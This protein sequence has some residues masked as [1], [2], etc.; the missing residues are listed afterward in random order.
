MV[1]EEDVEVFAASVLVSLLRPLTRQRDAWDKQLRRGE[2]KFVV[3]Q[4]DQ[5]QRKEKL[6]YLGM[7][8]GRREQV[9]SW[10]SWEGKVE[11]EAGKDKM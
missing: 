1:N 9:E 11:Y 2:M 10:E 3:R 7:C 8:D 6:N 4:S 5:E